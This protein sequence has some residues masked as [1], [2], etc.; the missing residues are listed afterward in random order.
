[1]RA[2][3]IERAVSDLEKQ[4]RG[5]HPDVSAVFVKPQSVQAAQESRGATTLSPDDVL[6]EDVLTG[7]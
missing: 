1:M 6:R 5:S 4:I 7:G 3:D 2:P